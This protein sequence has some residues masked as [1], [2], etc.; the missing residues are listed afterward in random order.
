LV[1]LGVD[2]YSSEFVLEESKVLRELGALHFLLPNGFPEVLDLFNQRHK[3]GRVLPEEVSI[4]KLLLQINQTLLQPIF[5]LLHPL[6]GLEV[7]VELV[8]PILGPF[9]VYLGRFL[10]YCLD[11]FGVLFNILEFVIQFIQRVHPLFEVLHDV[12]ISHLESP[13]RHLLQDSIS[14]LVLLA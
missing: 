6:E 9:L 3:S 7:F 5:F 11:F 2:I 8:H 4:L 1:D 12:S 13:L 10:D 14:F